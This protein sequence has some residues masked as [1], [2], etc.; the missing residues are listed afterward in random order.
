MS[1]GYLARYSTPSSYVYST[2]STVELKGVEIVREATDR[3]GGAHTL[4]KL[5]AAVSEVQTKLAEAERTAVM[6]SHLAA[7]VPGRVLEAVETTL[8][9]AGRD[10]RMRRGRHQRAG[11]CRRR[12]PERGG[13]RGGGG[14][15]GGGQ[16]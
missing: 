9:F 12:G 14:V 16:R 4:E 8:W 6:L 11:T 3:S 5:E 1:S 10:C 13:A 15:G 7:V 2:S